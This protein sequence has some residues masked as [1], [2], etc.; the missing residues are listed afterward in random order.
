MITI[1]RQLSDIRMLLSLNIV[2]S[3]AVSSDAMGSRM[4]VGTVRDASR[5]RANAVQRIREVEQWVRKRNCF[6]L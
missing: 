6:G 3:P 1:G 4:Q 2:A 5:T